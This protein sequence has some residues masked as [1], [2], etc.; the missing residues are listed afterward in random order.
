MT[1][2]TAASS[3]GPFH[4]LFRWVVGLTGVCEALLGLSIL[5]FAQDLQE[6]VAPGMLDE[7]LYLRII[8]MM[9]FWIG[10]LYLLIGIDP[11]RFAQLNRATRYLRL[12]LSGVFFAEGFW[13]LEEALLRWSYQLLAIFD[14]FLCIIQSLYLRSAPPK[15]RRQP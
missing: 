4:T 12:G 3:R 2:S 7:P 5:F 14:L 11:E 9:D 13:L 1:S 6:W 10:L 8:G 15:N